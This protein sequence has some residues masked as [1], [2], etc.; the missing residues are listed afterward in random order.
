MTP[1]KSFEDVYRIQ[2]KSIADLE[3]ELQKTREIFALEMSRKDA[4]I[5]RLKK[6]IVGMEEVVQA[7]RD[8]HYYETD[9]SGC[10][11]NLHNAGAVLGTLDALAA[12]S[13]AKEGA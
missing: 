3:D 13:E 1:S 10:A 12:R 8:Q 11:D 9:C 6:A 2:T 7:M 5:A 4:E